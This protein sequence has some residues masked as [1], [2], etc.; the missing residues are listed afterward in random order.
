M[1]QIE[2]GVKT[3]LGCPIIYNSLQYSLDASSVRFMVCQL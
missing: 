2:A 3:I 1:L